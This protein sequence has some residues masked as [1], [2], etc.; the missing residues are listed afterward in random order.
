MGT[1][2]QMTTPIIC[3]TMIR[4]NKLQKLRSDEKRITNITFHR[5]LRMMRADMFSLLCLA[6]NSDFIKHPHTTTVIKKGV[7]KF[8]E[9]ELN[10][11]VKKMDIF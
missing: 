3:G 6:T 9:S 5:K 11:R 10:Y 4:N 8:I 1:L 2:K 7:I